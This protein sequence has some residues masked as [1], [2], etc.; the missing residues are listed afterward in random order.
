MNDWV[1]AAIAFAVSLPAFHFAA[2]L[3][4]RVTGRSRGGMANLGSTTGFLA[5]LVV[6]AVLVSAVISSST[7]LRYVAYGVVGGIASLV[8]Q[9]LFGQPVDS[10]S[11]SPEGSHGNSPS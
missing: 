4:T 2:K 11:E 7:P 8:S 6:G 10:G 5:L 9:L 3:I 1:F